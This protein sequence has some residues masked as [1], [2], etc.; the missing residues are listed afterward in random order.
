V[1]AGER[2]GILGDYDVDG[3]TSSALLVRFLRSVGAV[4]PAVY[5][6]DRIKEGYGPNNT[7]MHWFKAQGCTVVVTVDCGTLSYAPIAEAKALGLDVLVVDHHIG[8]PRLP[9][10][11]AVVN[12]NRFDEE[13]ALG[14]LAAVGVAFLLVVATNR[15]LRQANWY[16]SSFAPPLRGGGERERAGGASE[17]DVLQ[18]LDIVALGTVCDVVPL[19]TLNRAF[20]AQGLKVMGRR[21][22]LGIRALME[23]ARVDEPPAA[24]HAGYVIGPRI[25]AGGRVGESDLGVR[26]L[27]TE[28]PDEA[29]ALAQR[30]DQYN[31]ERRAI[32][33][34]VQ[35]EALD[36]VSKHGSNMPV[37]FSVGE[38]WHPGVI[39]IVAGRLK[40]RFHRPV[41][42][43]A[44]DGDVAKAS[45]RSIKGVD[46][47]TAVHA[48]C[49]EGLLIAGG[50][51]AMAAGFS[52]ARDKIDALHAFLCERMGAAV[53]ALGSEPVL[54]IDA[55]IAPSGATLALLNQTEKLAPY[56]TGNAE[57]RFVVQHAQIIKVEPMSGGE[58]ARL[59]ATDGA[60]G[61]RVGS[62]RLKAI[63]FRIRDTPLGEALM[64]AQGK[65][66]HLAGKLKRNRWQGME[67]VDFLVDDI[68]LNV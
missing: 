13:N 58:H 23:I 30:L 40:E 61:G 50:G 52:V 43:L 59:I 22:N 15:T 51:H 19:T 21:Q 10:A 67:S 14:H 34:M 31:Q 60:F 29:T 48:A 55:V 56:G 9:E 47:G 28:D 62:G 18:W 33:T 26:I 44:L 39:G 27:T 42:V 5:I 24:Y 66:V 57:P 8:E 4:E 35:E 37:I 45:A 7:A 54:K 25:N 17:P 36:Q 64:Q 38:G 3:A 11:L 65:Q 12:P 32:E 6:P 1:I 53:D 41:A 16:A 46:F 68:V 49:A 2:I 63:A 20:V